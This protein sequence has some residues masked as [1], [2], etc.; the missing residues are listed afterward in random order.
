MFGYRRIHHVIFV[1]IFLFVISTP[2][3]GKIFQ[4]GITDANE[5]AKRENRHPNRFPK[6]PTSL[7]NFRKFP[8]TFE[9]AFNDHLP[10]REFLIRI[11]SELAVT[12][13]K[14]SPSKQ[15]LIGKKGHFFLASH[16]NKCNKHNDLIFSSIEIDK[17]TINYWKKYLIQKEPFLN[18]L[19]VPVLL[20]AIPTSPLFEFHNLPIFIR[21]QI[22]QSFLDEPP[23]QRIIND[24]P[25]NFVDKYLLFPYRRAFE[26][27]KKYSLFGEKN[28]HWQPSR[29]TKLVANCI[30][31]RFGIATYEEPGFDEFEKRITLSD[32][33]RF[34]GIEVY[35][36]DDLVY[37]PGFWESLQIQDK[38]PADVY[39]NSPVFPSSFYTV[40]PLQAGKLLVVGDSFTPALRFDLAR[41]FGEVLSVNFNLARN[42][43]NI[44]E[45]F[46]F[47][48]HDF[49][50][51]YIIFSQS[52][53]FFVN[54]EFIDNFYLM[55]KRSFKGLK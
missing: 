18:D 12:L 3:L 48:F 21:N 45:W 41:H 47:V 6:L 17:N 8:T 51:S 40:N 2:L 53:N 39:E 52:N 32:L 23:P 24:M 4:V 14:V 34:A 30:A 28:F 35:N 20:L 5:F 31:E 7:I 37:K 25:K 22:D 26:A 33:S 50:P 16:S 55:K 38:N 9:S 44:K 46:D 49:H 10:F 15:L 54:N 1:S 42:N 36:K 19:A 11:Y 29:Y 27:N 43:I 13:L